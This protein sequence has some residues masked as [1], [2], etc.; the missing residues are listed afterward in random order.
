M[1]G[2]M[3]EFMM[4]DKFEF[5]KMTLSDKPKILEICSRIWEGND[6]IPELFDEWVKDSKGEFT[7]VLHEGR[8]IGCSKLTFLTDHDA[9]LQGLRKDQD[10]KVKG[11]GEAV[12]HYYLD[13]LK[14]YDNLKSIRF[15]AYFKD[16]KSV[17]AAR[18]CGF[19]K[20]KSFSWKHLD[21]DPDT[22]TVLDKSNRTSVIKDVD[23]IMKYIKESDYFDYMN[24]LICL[25]WEVHPYSDDLIKTRFIDNNMCYG[26]EESGKIKALVLAF[27]ARGLSLS[28]FNADN[29]D[30]GKELL[31][32]LKIPALKCR[33]KSIKFFLPEH[34]SLRKLINDLCFVSWEQE[35]DYLLY[36]FPVDKLK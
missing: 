26:I 19:V 32:Y 34:P 15:A 29:I 1:V 6:F 12:T 22:V 16:P 21:F 20:V 7:A 18:K 25:D 35:N 28:F 9:W 10:C 14:H 11:V 5:R 2:L 3:L 17:S 8:I 30:Y 24:N 31:E 27:P 33:W 36:E 4:I 23:S 13:K